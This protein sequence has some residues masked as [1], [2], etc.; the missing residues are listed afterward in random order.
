LVTEVNEIDD[1]SVAIERGA[2]AQQ[3]WWTLQR[4]GLRLISIARTTL[5]RPTVALNVCDNHSSQHSKPTIKPEPTLMRMPTF[6]TRLAVLLSTLMFAPFGAWA[7]FSD[8]NMPR[9]VTPISHEAYDLHMLILWICVAIGVVVFGAMFYSILRHRKS[10]G[11]EP[12][13]FHHST[14]AEVLWTA[15]PCVILIA[16]ALPATSALVAMEDTSESA[17]TIKVTGY[18]WKWKYDY[19][20]DGVSFYSSLASTSR[21]AIYSKED[22]RNTPNYLLE[23]DKNVVIPIN[24]KV[25]LLLTSDDVIHAWWI[26][27]FGM[28]KDAIPGFINEIWVKAEKLG[29]YRGQCAEL[30][31]KDH[32]FMPIVVEVKSQTDYDAWIAEQ[33]QT[34]VSRSN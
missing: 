24:T 23:V 14:T 34:L 10:L 33:K 6:K 9:G 28:K 19:L 21:A 11:F 12:A 1:S 20:E 18:Q 3:H 27:Q 26:P 31:G 13:Q 8:L 25:R 17:L 7:A 29:T 22:P 2:Q 5:R 4:A 30:C 15:I 32:G 16:M